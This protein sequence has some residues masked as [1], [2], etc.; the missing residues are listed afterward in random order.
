[1][2]DQQSAAGDL[3]EDIRDDESVTNAAAEAEAVQTEV[4]GEIS[5]AAA[6]SADGERVDDSNDSNGT[7]DSDTIRDGTE[8]GDE[9]TVRERKPVGRLLAVAVVVLAV[10][11][12]GGAAFAGAMIQPYLVDRATVNTKLEIAR[13]ASDA[14]TTLWTY[15]PENVD[16]LADRAAKY[17]S[18][19]FEAQYRKFMD[20]IAAPN[21]Q[22]KVTNSTHVTAVAVASLDGVDATA[23]VYT[24]TTSTSPVSKDI[25]SLKYLSYRLVMK[26]DHARWLVVRM[27]TITS[28]DLTPQL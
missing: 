8:Q 2:E 6:E 22:A 20:A 19:D 16:T 7:A 26:R 5:D 13:T 1:V 4:A 14:I 27:T 24:N 25:P 17:L 9:A 15:T 10:L 28:L 11:F 21:K 18:G 3:I 23:I 12:V